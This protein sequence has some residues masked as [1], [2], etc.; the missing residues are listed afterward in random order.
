MKAALRTLPP[1]TMPKRHI[2]PSVRFTASKP[3]AYKNSYP[4]SHKNRSSRNRS[5]IPLSLPNSALGI[6]YSSA[7]AT[8]KRNDEGISLPA[9]G[10]QHLSPRCLRC[11]QAFYRPRGTCRGSGISGTGDRARVPRNLRARSVRREGFMYDRH[12]EREREREGKP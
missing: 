10:D 12:A 4:P 6:S 2:E 11:R 5:P 7:T 3:R 8:T 1:K 9:R